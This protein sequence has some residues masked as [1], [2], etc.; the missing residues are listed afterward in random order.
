ME[1]NQNKPPK[2]PKLPRLS[3]KLEPRLTG[4]AAIGAPRQGAIIKADGKQIGYIFFEGGRYY[5]EN[6]SQKWRIKLAFK[7]EMS[8][9][10]PCPFEWRNLKI[11][12]SA[13]TLEETKEVV[14]QNW[15]MICA[16]N[17]HFI[18]D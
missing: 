5:N 12:Y 17:L 1:N 11:K 10:N 8:K 7:R 2:A 9:E 4:L 3:F 14:R 15:G 6:A 18:E 16:Q 13:D